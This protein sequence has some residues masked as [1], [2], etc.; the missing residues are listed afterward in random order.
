MTGL[1][2][3]KKQYIP[4]KKFEEILSSIDVDTIAARI[5]H[6]VLSPWTDIEALKQAIF[7]TAKLNLRCLI[8]SPPLLRLAREKSLAENICIGSVASFPYGYSTLESK[9]KEVEDLVALGADEIDVVIN[10][11][12]YLLGYRDNVVNEA[13][14]ITEIC[15]ENNVVCKIIVEAPAL[16]YNTLLDITKDIA[17]NAR[18]QYIKTSSGYGPRKTLPEDVY[19]INTVLEKMGIRDKIG[20]KAAGGIRSGLQAL[21]MIMAGSD[22]IGSSTPAKILD[23]IIRLKKTI[24]QNE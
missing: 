16:D 21:T 7:E 15:R 4:E 23:D 13:R 24:T 12:M 11:Q 5:D 2:S 10:Y 17:L 8:V 6:A 19:V 18:P 14:A 22:I 3:I 1:T 9:V 20:I